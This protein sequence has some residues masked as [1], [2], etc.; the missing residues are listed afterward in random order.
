MYY[1]PEQ[2]MN[3]VATEPYLYF[4]RAG[5][6]DIVD[7]SCPSPFQELK[8]DEKARYYVSDMTM[9]YLAAVE[10]FVRFPYDVCAPSFLRLYSRL[11]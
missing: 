1:T 2:R 4:T 5:C 7:R 9:G 3:L 8:F 6:D 11:T 10:S